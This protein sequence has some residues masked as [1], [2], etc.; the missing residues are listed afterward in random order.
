MLSTP[1]STK[2]SE[3]SEDEP[4]AYPV[5]ITYPT[6]A[7]PPRRASQGS[8]IAGSSAQPANRR[9]TRTTRA[10]WALP[11]FGRK[12]SVADWTTSS[13][14]P[15]PLRPNSAYSATH[16]ASPTEETRMSFR[17]VPT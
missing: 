2:F 7:P 8:P 14:E 1:L 12:R 5:V 3:I 15:G 17:K 9:Q 16:G 4:D 10:H 11:L 6:E 13:P